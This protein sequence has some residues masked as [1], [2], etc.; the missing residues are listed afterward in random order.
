MYERLKKAKA[1]SF[2]LA[3]ARKSLKSSYSRSEKLF[4]IHKT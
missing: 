4:D 2:I 1:P 3:N